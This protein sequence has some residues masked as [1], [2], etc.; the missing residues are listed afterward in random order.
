MSE[1]EWVEQPPEPPDQDY[2]EPPVGERDALGPS[3]PRRSRWLLG[4]MAVLAIGAAG[5]GGYLLLA[6]EDE[7]GERRKER[8]AISASVIRS[9]PP[10]SPERAALMW[11]RDVQ[12]RNAPGALTR[13]APEAGVELDQLER[14]I[15]VGVSSFVGVPR[16]VEVT[17]KGDLVTVYLTVSPPGSSAPPRN[18]SLNLRQ[19]DGEWLLRDN[20][21]MQQAVARVYAARAAAA[22]Q[23]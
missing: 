9:E 17:G 11:W 7:E 23:E 16:I 2:I 10:A 4:G 14:Q 8:R 3:Y 20:S 21:L 5:A 13:Y 22:D 15:A 12:F 19:I 1:E 18:L 6:D